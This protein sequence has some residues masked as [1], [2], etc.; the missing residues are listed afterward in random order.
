MLLPSDSPHATL[1]FYHPTGEK[2]HCFQ[3]HNLPLTALY[4][5]RFL[6]KV[7]RLDKLHTSVICTVVKSVTKRA[8]LSKQSSFASLT[9]DQSMQLVTVVQPHG[10]G[11]L[12]QALITVKLSE[13]CQVG[14]WKG[15]KEAKWFFLLFTLLHSGTVLNFIATVISLWYRINYFRY[16]TQHF[17]IW[18]SSLFKNNIIGGKDSIQSCEL[19]PLPLLLLLFIAVLTSCNWSKSLRNQTK[20]QFYLDWEQLFWSDYVLGRTVIRGTFH[21]SYFGSD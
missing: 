9:A 20:V 13:V 6:Y 2:A 15:E 1:H 14:L 8:L 3:W 10:L 17:F 11:L 19:L 18:T 21:T 4:P 7:A 16:N 12:L 5:R